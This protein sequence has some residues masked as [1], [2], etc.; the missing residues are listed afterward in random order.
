MTSQ[1]PRESEWVPACPNCGWQPRVFSDYKL[2]FKS[3]AP[4]PDCQT[5]IR[6]KAPIAGPLASGI[7]LSMVLVLILIEG[8]SVLWIVGLVSIALVVEV[9]LRKFE[10]FEVAE[11]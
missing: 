8:F 2:K 6:L 5:N 1:R 9:L 7:A 10:T 4:C 11:T 3:S